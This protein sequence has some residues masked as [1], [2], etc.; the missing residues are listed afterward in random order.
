MID[1]NRV[2]TESIEAINEIIDSGANTTSVI[3]RGEYNKDLSGLTTENWKSLCDFYLN[4]YKLACTNLNVECS[5]EL[6]FK[7]EEFIE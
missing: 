1:W 4:N 6:I 7:A 2:K 3:L 5:T